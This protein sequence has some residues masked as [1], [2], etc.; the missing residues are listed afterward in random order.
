MKPLHRII[1]LIAAERFFDYDPDRL[2]LGSLWRDMVCDDVFVPIVQDKPLYA[3][4]C[5]GDDRYAMEVGECE[6]G[7]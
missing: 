4:P 7:W 5:D 3:T 1:D 2:P 6:F